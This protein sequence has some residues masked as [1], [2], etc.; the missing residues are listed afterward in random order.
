MLHRTIGC[1]LLLAVAGLAEGRPVVMLTGYWAPTAE[2]IYRFSDNPELNPEGWIGEDWEGRGYDIYAFFPAFNVNTREFEVDYQATWSDFWARTDEYHPEIIIS[3][4][5][6]DNGPWEIEYRAVNRTNWDPD[7]IEPYYP[8]PNPP[9]STIAGGESRYATLPLY[10]IRNAVNE[11][12][13]THAWVDSYGDPG[14]FLCNYIAY[15]GM[16]YQAQHAEEDD[17]HYCRAAGFIHVNGEMPL[18]EATVATQVTLR[19]V[20]DYY[21]NIADLAGSVSAASPLENCIVSLRDQDNQVFETI[22]DEN[23][24]FLY[25]DLQ[26]GEYAVNALSGRYSYY[27]GDFVFDSPDDF[28]LIEM[29][30]YDPLEPVTYCQGPEELVNLDVSSFVLTGAYFPPELLEQYL[31]CHLNTL[32]FTAPVNSGDCMNALFLY[33]GNPLEGPFA[34][35]EGVELPEFQQGDLVEAWLSEIYFLTESDIEDGLTIAYGINNP[36]HDI[37]Y[38]DNAEANPNGNLIR[39]GPAW[40]HADEAYGIQGNWD[41]R[42]GVFGTAEAVDTEPLVTVS[43]YRLSNYPNPFNPSTTISFTAENPRASEIVIYSLLG[44]KVKTLAVG[45]QHGSGE[46]S[47]IWNGT[48]DWNQPVASGVYLYR[49]NTPGSPVGKM[50]LVR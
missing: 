37:G 48:D 39:T 14:S 32:L 38:T 11:Q 15:L 31:G 47:V 8:T 46:E 44:R 10:N 7:D 3:F 29:D 6:T 42:L 23:G 28:L 40:Q 50:I 25:E 13:A 49:L 35:L 17:E 26:F 30:E 41:L 19:A 2:M 33:R 24:D 45:H 27:Q 9:D 16:W 21:E 4:G 43:D 22:P 18:L 5:A 36:D 12:T 1:L 20:F 34:L